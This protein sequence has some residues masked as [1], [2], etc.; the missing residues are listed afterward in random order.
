MKL[1]W[2]KDSERLYETGVD[3]V[4]LFPRRGGNY[5]A[6]V[7]WNG[8]TAI[9]ERP[10]GAEASSIFANNAK[11]LSIRS[12]ED[13]AATLEAFGY[14]VEFSQCIG[15]R[16]LA[17]G[18]YLKQQKSCSFGLCY[19]TLLGND[20]NDTDYGYKIHLIYGCEASPSEKSTQT[21]NDSPEP[22]T[23]SWEFS[24][25]PVRVGATNAKPT[26]HLVI[27]STKIPASNLE[28]LE[29]ILYGTDNA[30]AR[31]PLPNEVLAIA[32]SVDI[33]FDGT[34]LMILGATAG[35]VEFRPDGTLY[36]SPEFV[37]GEYDTILSLRGD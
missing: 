11:Y 14:P 21:Q 10:S 22:I 13:F 12:A 33:F 28:K 5:Q 35:R 24:S 20:E 36:I 37:L 27:D 29:D 31:L 4:V 18:L 34:Q 32:D 26:A 30:D 17:P 2:D 16:Q 1:N 15:S 9:N 7:A 8:V 3:R 23:Y 25:T 19:R 6:G